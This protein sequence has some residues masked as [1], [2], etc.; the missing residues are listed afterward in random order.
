MGQKF[1]LVETQSRNIL[2]H[3]SWPNQPVAGVRDGSS[4][5]R[6][7][8]TSSLQVRRSP[9]DRPQSLER[10]LLPLGAFPDLPLCTFKSLLPLST[11]LSYLLSKMRSVLSEIWEKKIALSVIFLV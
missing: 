1:N 6:D 3:D 4:R 2:H 7:Q 8:P 10:R 5:Q 11:A 9:Q